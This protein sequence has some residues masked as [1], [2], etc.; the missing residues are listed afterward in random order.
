MQGAVLCDDEGQLSS[1]QEG[2]ESQFWD[3]TGP[4]DGNDKRLFLTARGSTAIKDSSGTTQDRVMVLTR[5]CYFYECKEQYGNKDQFLD[6]TG[7]CDGN[8]K[9]LFL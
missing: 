2:D 3:N 4:C 9:R 1:R 7:P 5:G 8:N 6:S